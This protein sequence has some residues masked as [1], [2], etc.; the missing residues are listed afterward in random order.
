MK[1]PKATDRTSSVVLRLGANTKLELRVGSVVLVRDYPNDSFGAV[2]SSIRGAQVR[3]T[4]TPEGKP[5][6]VPA[7]MI[8]SVHSSHA[9]QLDPR[10]L[11]KNQ[12][13]PTKLPRKRKAGRPTNKEAPQTQKVL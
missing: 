12:P 3:L 9:D 4:F 1:S 7:G 13:P 5:R 11:P 10:R 2:V 8:L 6:Q